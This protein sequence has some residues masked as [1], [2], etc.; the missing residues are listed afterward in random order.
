MKSLFIQTAE[1]SMA[2]ANCPVRLNDLP[3]LICKHTGWEYS[4][5]QTDTGCFLQPTFRNMPYHNSFVPE[6]DVV[7]SYN[8][9]QTILYIQGQPAKF[10]RRFMVFWFSSLLMIEVFLLVLAITSNLDSLFP[11]FAPII[12]CAFGY[13]LCKTATGATFKSIIKAIQ[14]E[15]K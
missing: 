2:N 13:L 4:F 11:F 5:I 3:N 6:I 8:D 14:K 15:L 12:M 1:H 9:T 10:I 7:V